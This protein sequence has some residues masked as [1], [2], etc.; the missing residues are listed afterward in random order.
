V[1]TPEPSSYSLCPQSKANQLRMA[2]RRALEWIGMIFLVAQTGDVSVRVML[3]TY[4]P[5]KGDR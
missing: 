4:I 3:S 1:E 2:A 5:S